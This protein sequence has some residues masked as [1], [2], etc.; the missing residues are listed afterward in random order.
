M[1]WL[2][3]YADNQVGPSGAA[4]LGEAL[5]CNTTLTELQLGSTGEGKREGPL[6]HDVFI[7]CGALLLLSCADNQVGADGAARLAEALQCNANLTELDLSC[8]VQG[9]KEGIGK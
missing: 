9:R 3:S 7:G 1:F 5:Q 8:T 2:F 4:R 6:L